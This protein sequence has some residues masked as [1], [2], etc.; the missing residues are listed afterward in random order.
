MKNSRASCTTHHVQPS[1]QNDDR[2][3]SSLH[4]PLVANAIVLRSWQSKI[5][6]LQSNEFSLC[7]L[8]VFWGNYS[9]IR[10]VSTR[11]G[12]LFY[13]G[14]AYRSPSSGSQLAPFMEISQHN[15]DPASVYKVNSSKGGRLLIPF[16]ELPKEMVGYRASWGSQAFFHMLTMEYIT[17]K[18]REFADNGS[19]Y[20]PGKKWI[21]LAKEAKIPTGFMNR[22]PEVLELFCCPDRGFL[23]R[24]GDDYAFNDKN[25][26][27]EK[28]LIDQGKL[29]NKRSK[30]AKKSKNSK[31]KS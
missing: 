7:Y 14:I 31:K 8:C 28:H 25:K 9:D 16:V 22:L 21:A 18:S 13:A 19:I 6:P 4:I 23:E 26:K 3:H 27:V 24:Q 20:I 1:L 29:K 17:E 15:L 5:Q 12:H 2:R 11:R 10:K 30:Q